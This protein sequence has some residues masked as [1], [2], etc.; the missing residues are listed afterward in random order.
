MKTGFILFLLPLSASSFT[1]KPSTAGG[2]DTFLY[3]QYDDA[4]EDKIYQDYADKWMNDREPQQEERKKQ[5]DKPKIP[6]FE[7][8]YLAA[9][10]KR[11]AEQLESSN[12]QARDEDWQ[13]M[14]EEVKKQFGI[15]NSG[16]WEEW[17]KAAQNADEDDQFGF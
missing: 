12:S 13:N 4:V 5:P 3:S 7:A 2:F 16:D 6:T 15:Q 14:S 1:V 17:E 8:D 10:R 9:A 11:A